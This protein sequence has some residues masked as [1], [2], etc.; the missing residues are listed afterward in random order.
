MSAEDVMRQQLGQYPVDQQR[1]LASG[2]R[3]FVDHFRYVS[4][5]FPVSS[6]FDPKA[7]SPGE[8]CCTCDT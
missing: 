1:Q 7:T 3:A 4:H 5:P 6:N 2:A 8:F